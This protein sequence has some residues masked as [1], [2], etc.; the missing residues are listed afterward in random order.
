MKAGA[1]LKRSVASRPGCGKSPMDRAGA[2]LVEVIVAV[3]IVGVGIAGVAS[4]TAASARILV[5]VRALDE[6]YTLLQSF[7]DSAAASTGGGVE[8]GSQ[9]LPTGVLTWSVPGSPGAEAW[10]RFDH[11]VLSAPIQIDF[12]V[13]ALVGTP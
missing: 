5:Q 9:T 2:S 13:P 8:S 11:A 1:G 7:V 6:T 10:A 12:V 4:L 3:V